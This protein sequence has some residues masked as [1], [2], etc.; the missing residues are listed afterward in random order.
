M[1]NTCVLLKT[2]LFY[3]HA[4]IYA[5]EALYIL[6]NDD[7]SIIDASG[8]AENDQLFIK[9]RRVSVSLQPKIMISSL[10]VYD[11]DIR[12]SNIDAL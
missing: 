9:K 2:Y 12:N 4:Y 3:L 6:K 1:V 7:C 8:K 5:K 11:L 10:S